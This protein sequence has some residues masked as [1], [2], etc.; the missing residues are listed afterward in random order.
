MVEYKLT[1]KF[2]DAVIKNLLNIQK[3]KGLTPEN[4]VD[5]AEN[6]DSPL[7]D[8]FEWDNLEAGKKYRLYQAR[9]LVNE[10]KVIIENK[11]YYAFESVSVSVPYGNQP[12]ENR[13]YISVLEI[14]NDEVLK[15]QVISSALKHLAYWEK[16]NERYIELSPI[17]KSARAVRKKLEKQ[18]QN[19]QK[20]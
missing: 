5:E 16:Q 12:T 6:K 3:Q 4:I 18:W 10:V 20:K 19:K 17:I 14:F 9:I 2:T 8:F 7:H 15:K 1:E 11:E 13:E